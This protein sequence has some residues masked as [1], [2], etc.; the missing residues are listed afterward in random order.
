MAKIHTKL[1]PGAQYHAGFRLAAVAL[2][3]VVMLANL[4]P[5][6]RQNGGELRIDLVDIGAVH[7]AARDIGLVGDDNQQKAFALQ[8]LERCASAVCDDELTQITWRVR[9]AVADDCFVQHTI[10]IEKDGRP[11][12][13]HR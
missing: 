3:V 5:V 4:D 1:V 2:F 13:R 10:A 9:L 12:R 8:F 7:P 11:G 6:E